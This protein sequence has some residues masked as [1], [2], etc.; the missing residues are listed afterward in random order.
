M[1]RARRIP[2]QP[3]ADPAQI[4]AALKRELAQARAE[5]DEAVAQQTATAEVLQVINASPGDLA[6]VFDAVLEKATRVCG[7]VFGT[8][9]AY[10]GEHF[11]VVAHRNLPAAYVEFMKVGQTIPFGPGTAP[12]RLLAGENL[13]HIIDGQA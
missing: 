6:P 11:R 9:L 2:D 12:R 1:P 7:A 10:D 3:T 4:V 5:R 13:V 8:M